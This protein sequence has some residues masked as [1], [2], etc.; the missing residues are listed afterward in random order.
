MRAYSA[1]LFAVQQVIGGMTATLQSPGLSRG[2]VAIGQEEDGLF[3][4]L[5]NCLKV[6][7]HLFS[8]PCMLKG[9]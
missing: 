6:F 8:C 5:Q 1:F 3:E 4:R 9:D 2:A 7:I